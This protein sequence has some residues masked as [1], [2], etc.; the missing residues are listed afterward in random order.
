VQLK[1]DCHFYKVSSSI[2][3]TNTRVNVRYNVNLG[4]TIMTE[5]AMAHL[6]NNKTIYIVSNFMPGR[7][8]FTQNDK[9]S[10]AERLKI[11]VFHLDHLTLTK[12]VSNREVV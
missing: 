7:T 5:C 8:G 9:E 1:N 11:L 6:S 3:G 4:I 10:L 12:R 2:D